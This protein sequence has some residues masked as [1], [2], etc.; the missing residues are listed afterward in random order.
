MTAKEILEKNVFNLMRPSFHTDER[1]HEITRI[2]LT[3]TEEKQA[4]FSAMKELCE[5]TWDAAEKFQCEASE[6][7]YEHEGWPEDKKPKN[8]FP[9]KQEFI[10]S[11]FP[12][13]KDSGLVVSNGTT[14]T[15]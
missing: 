10:N 3:M 2:W 13:S 7:S 8:I 6:I 1:T 12:E 5:L 11:L 14:S 4:I 15:E 9:N